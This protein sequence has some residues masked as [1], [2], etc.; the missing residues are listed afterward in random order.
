MKFIAVLFTLM[1]SLFSFNSYATLIN[2]NTQ[3][4]EPLKYVGNSTDCAI[5]SENNDKMNAGDD[6]DELQVNVDG[7][8]GMN[9]WQF[10]EKNGSG[11][12]GMISFG[13]DITNYKLMAVFKGANAAATLPSGFI[14]Y[15]L[16]NTQ[17]SFT[18]DTMFSKNGEPQNVS[19]IS[20]Y[21]IPTDGGGEPQCVGDCT[22]VPEPSTLLILSA[23]LL[24][25][26]AKRRK[27]IK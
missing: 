15:L 9:T 20:F 25:L 11:K 7:F 12:K 14:G 19:H 21:Y 3:L 27:L 24:G 16:D 23:G 1:C 18:W 8:F 4:N 5:S 10:L 6:K 2:C 17:T 22:S 13:F 26:A